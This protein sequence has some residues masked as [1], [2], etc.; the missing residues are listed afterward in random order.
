[1]K[2]LNTCLNMPLVNISVTCFEEDTNGIQTIPFSNFPLMNC[3]SISICL[4][5]SCWTG[6]WATM[7]AVLLLQYNLIGMLISLSSSF[8]TRC[9][10]RTSH[11]PLSINLNS[12]SALLR[13]T[14]V[15][16][17]LLQVTRLPHTNVQYP[18]VDFRSSTDPAQSVSVKTSTLLS[19]FFLMKSPLPG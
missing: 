8:R 4:V 9:I 18:E 15:Y 19:L 17:L 14:T 6:L 2:T 11:I 3:Q 5:R 13:A 1:M 16:F 12:A 10:Q 7:I